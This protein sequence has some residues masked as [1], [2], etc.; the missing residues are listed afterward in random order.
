MICPCC[1]GEFILLRKFRCRGAVIASLCESC[2]DKAA[3][4]SAQIRRDASIISLQLITNRKFI[5]LDGI[6]ATPTDEPSAVESHNKFRRQ[7][8]TNPNPHEDTPRLNSVAGE[9]LIASLELKDVIEETDEQRLDR[10]K[11]ELDRLFPK[12]DDT[13]CWQEEVVEDWRRR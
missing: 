8:F 1:K 7:M 12:V 10:R 11:A 3:K 6:V 9:T 5:Y 2:Y 13:T 4:K